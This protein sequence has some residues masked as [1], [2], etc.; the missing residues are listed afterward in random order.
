VL[1]HDLYLFADE[2]YREFVLTAKPIFGHEP[3]GDRQNVV[4]LDPFRSVTGLWRA[5]RSDDIPEQGS[6]D[7]R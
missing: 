3:G 6:H 2:V 7:T 1:K 5:D 4:L